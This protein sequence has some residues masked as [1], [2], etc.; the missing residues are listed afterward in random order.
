MNKERQRADYM[1]GSRT[2]PHGETFRCQGEHFDMESAGVFCNKGV[3]L[4]A[5]CL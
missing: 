5:V 1:K 3:P 2:S 4:V